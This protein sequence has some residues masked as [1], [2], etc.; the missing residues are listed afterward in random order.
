MLRVTPCATIWHCEPVGVQAIA[1]S[2]VEIDYGV[3]CNTINASS[4]TRV[5]TSDTNC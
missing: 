2:D 5:I 1:V 3:V 4:G